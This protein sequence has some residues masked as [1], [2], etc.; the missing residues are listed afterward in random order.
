[1]A[2]HP[3]GDIGERSRGRE[4]GRRRDSIFGRGEE[5]WGDRDWRDTNGRRGSWTPERG[6]GRSPYSG[7]ERG[8]GGGRRDY[9][10]PR[11][12][13][14][15]ERS[16]PGHRRGREESWRGQ[17]ED[18]HYGPDDWRGGLPRDETSHL[19]ASNKV[20]GTAVYGVDGRRLGTIYNFMV[21]KISGRVEYVVMSYGGF[22]GMGTRYYALPWGMLTYDTREGGYHVD[23][24]ERD[25]ED[26]PSFDEATEPVFDRAYGST[27]Y[28]YYGI[29]Y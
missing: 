20:E 23:M 17:D 21:N 2:E 18:R 10:E 14:G 5:R 9:D 1:M 8:Y 26:A 29:P 3:Y 24:T 4:G 6:R 13:G 27:I 15:R 22:L 7:G 25:L 12:W 16:G 28:S 19:I 11:D